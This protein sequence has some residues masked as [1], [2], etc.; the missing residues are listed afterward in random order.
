MYHGDTLILW[1]IHGTSLN[2]TPQSGTLWQQFPPLTALSA[3]VCPISRKTGKVK[4]QNSLQ[5]SCC[6]CDGKQM[7]VRYIMITPGIVRSVM[8]P[9]F[10]L[11]CTVLFL[12]SP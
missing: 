9:T 11:L 4:P 10:K 7:G 12:F 2:E 5:R 3:S 8:M 1:P 6:G